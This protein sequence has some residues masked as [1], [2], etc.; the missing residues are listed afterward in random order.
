MKKLLFILPIFSS[1]LFS[2][3]LDDV[4]DL[5]KKGDYSK[6]CVYAA[7]I[8][9]RM[10]HN[11]PFFSLYGYA[12]L[13]SD[14]INSLV[15]P[16][17]KLV[18]TKEGRA[19]ARYFASILF[20]KKMLYNAIVD[21]ED[22]SYINLPTTEYILSQVFTKYVK[23]DFT[24]DGDAWVFSDDEDK[25]VKHILTLEVEDEFPK[26]YLKTFKDKKLLKTRIYW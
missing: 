1:Y 12:C 19:D 6:A 25:D 13:K 17:T 5:Y 11:E 22:I 14:N 3:T 8:F 20:Q 10:G 16:I 18:K 21:N 2:I 23:K 15:K 26:L 7:S 4:V 24:K 9:D